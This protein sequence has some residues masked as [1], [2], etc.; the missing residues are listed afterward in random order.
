MR[1]RTD[2][3]LKNRRGETLTESIVSLLVFT[4]LIASVT[5][6]II[7]SVRISSRA[8]TDASDIQRDINNALIGAGDTAVFTCQEIN[9]DGV[10]VHVILTSIT[11]DDGYTFTAFVPG[12]REGWCTCP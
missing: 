12:G 5:L 10:S 7:V 3:I 1:R 4:V 8:S 9:L 11:A 6:T 2:G